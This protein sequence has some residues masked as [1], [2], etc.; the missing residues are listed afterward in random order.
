MDRGASLIRLLGNIGWGRAGWPHERDL[1][2]FEARVTGA[3]RECPCIV[4]CL[5]DVRALPRR[6]ILHGAF[7]THPVTV[8]GNIVR[9]NRHYVELDELL[10]RQAELEPG[11]T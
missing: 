8:C 4:V 3:A 7:E 6:I 1:L 5:Y 10:E 2:A 11:D 9:E